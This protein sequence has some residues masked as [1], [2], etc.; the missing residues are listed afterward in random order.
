MTHEKGPRAV[1]AEKIAER[2][3]ARENASA[4]L[5]ALSR[6]AEAQNA[7]AGPAAEMAALDAAEA[8][9]SLAWSRSPDAS[10]PTPNV[11]LRAELAAKLD[12]ARI[13][14]VAARRA[15]Q[16]L[17]GEHAAEARRI[18]EIES[19]FDALVAEIVVDELAP[20]VADFATATADLAR[21]R[22]RIGA[23]RELALRSVEGRGLSI[24]TFF[25]K[26]ERI[27]NELGDALGFPAPA[28]V[29]AAESQADFR[30]LMANLSHD[31]GAALP[32]TSTT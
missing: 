12:A 11:A 5:A 1:L 29:R 31:A 22:A 3:A 6:L 16:S 4:V 9:A 13:G 10:P 17:T 2:D 14:A 8:S 28:L 26:L 7:E 21:Q 15:A 30:A 24:P 32:N 20:L 18:A 25:R 27:D 23:A 19:D